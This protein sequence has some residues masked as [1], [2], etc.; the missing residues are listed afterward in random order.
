MFQST[1]SRF[2]EKDPVTTTVVPEVTT[3][4]NKRRRRQEET[5]TT[6]IAVEETTTTE[7]PTTTAEPLPYDLNYMTIPAVSNCKSYSISQYL[8]QEVVYLIRPRDMYEGSYPIIV[9]LH[10]QEN[11]NIIIYNIE[12]VNSEL[13][14]YKIII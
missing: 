3:L 7:I 1:L 12:N 2:R 9:P 10:D 4:I 5:T 11:I 13:K 6:E 14:I 8:F